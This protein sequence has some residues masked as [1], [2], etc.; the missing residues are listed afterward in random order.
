MEIVIEQS[1]LTEERI[2]YQTEVPVS[3]KCRKCKNDYMI[4]FLQ[5]HDNEGELVKQRPEWLQETRVKVWPHDSSVTNVYLCTNCGAMRA[6]WNQ[7]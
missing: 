1:K 3:L 6:T 2:T 4:L 7:G 5:V